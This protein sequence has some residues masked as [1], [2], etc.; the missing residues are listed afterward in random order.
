MFFT[1]T[2]KDWVPLLQSE[3]QKNTIVESLRFLVQ[4]KR[5]KVFAFVI[6]PNHIHVIWQVL[7]GHKY[8]DV[9]R[10]FLKYTAQT[11]KNDLLTEES[12]LIEKLKSSNKDRKY[13]IW[14]YKSLSVELNTKAIFDQKLEYIYNNPVQAKWKLSTVPEDYYYS[15]AG[16]YMEE[17]QSFD[18]I[19][20]YL[21]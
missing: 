4:N 3:K 19:S 14:Q 11:I 12:P 9:Q 15:S 1:A 8:S 21:D 13:Q 5:V 18:F 7:E 2:I 16:F 20:H 17:N 10:D 6:M